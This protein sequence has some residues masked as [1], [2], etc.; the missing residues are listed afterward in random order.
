MPGSRQLPIERHLP[1][2]GLPRGGHRARSGEEIDELVAVA[3]PQAVEQPHE[4]RPRLGSR[5]MAVRAPAQRE[6]VRRADEPIAGPD[7]GGV[8][9][10]AAAQ[11]DRLPAIQGPGASAGLSERFAPR[12]HPQLLPESAAGRAT[13]Y[14]LRAER[15]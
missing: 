12:E 10:P 15:E 6:Q 7:A 11:D 3:G 4:E 8:V 9:T 14:G 5:D 13:R 1:G 2:V